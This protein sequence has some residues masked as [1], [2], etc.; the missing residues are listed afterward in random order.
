MRETFMHRVTVR[1]HIVE[2]VIARRGRLHICDRL[3][4][5]RCVLLVIDMMNMF[6]APGAPAEVPAARAITLNINHLAARLRVAGMPIA[7]VTR[8]KG[9]WKHFVDRFVAAEMRKRTREAMRIGG[10][11]QT[12]W[13]ELAVAPEDWRVYKTRYSAFADESGLEEALGR[14][15]IDTVLIAGTKTNICCESTARDAMMRGFDVV[16]V[17]DCC[18]AL[19]DEEHRSALENV[20]QQ[21]GDVLTADEVVD[22]LP[23]AGATDA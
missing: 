1:P 19:S 3:D 20:I 11:G 16:M 7:W 18:A 22:R 15:G 4:P 17:A 13:H 14:A 6:V 8:G 10:E 5:G 23:S 12:L 21:F 2:R 9:E